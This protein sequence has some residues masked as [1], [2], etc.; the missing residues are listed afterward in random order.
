MHR[1]ID[2]A[3]DRPIESDAYKQGCGYG[4]SAGFEKAYLNA[5]PLVDS[6]QALIICATVPVALSEK[7]NALET[8]KKNLAD[9]KQTLK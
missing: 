8:A 1:G 2:F 6:I 3:N 5:E 4:F 9:Y 7:I